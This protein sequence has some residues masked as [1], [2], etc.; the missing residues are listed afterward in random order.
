MRI[1]LKS[2]IHTHV[3]DADLK[4]EGSITLPKELMEKADI[5]PYE[6]VHVLNVSTGGRYITY[7]MEGDCV[8]VNG[9]LARR[10]SIGDEV[11]ILS[12]VIG[13]IIPRFVEWK[14]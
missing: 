4:C 2:K 9:A 5:E 10:V 8:R 11:I 1:R 12:Y 14:S 6:Q 13:K 7:A 3:E